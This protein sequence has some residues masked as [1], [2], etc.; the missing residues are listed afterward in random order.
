M[1]TGLEF[2]DPKNIVVNRLRQITTDDFSEWILNQS[3]E[4][5]KV[6]EK[7]PFYESFKNAYYG[8]DEKF[9]QRKFTS[10]LKKYASL[11]NLGFN[12]PP[13]SSCITFFQFTK[14]K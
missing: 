6:Y 1:K 13:A 10:Y 7:K 8:E 2:Y 9:S 5:D 4:N 12:Q 3:F 14:K 11:N